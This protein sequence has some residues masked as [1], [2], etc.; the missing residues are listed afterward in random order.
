[1]SR[2]SYYCST[3]CNQDHRVSDGKPVEHECRIIPPLALKA[4]MCGD[5]ERA[6]E[7]LSTTQARYMRRGV[8]MEAV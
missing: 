4:E 7:I 8:K 3:Y 6:V 1:M 5:Y 2:H